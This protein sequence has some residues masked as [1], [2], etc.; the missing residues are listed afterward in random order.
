MLKKLIIVLIFLLPIPI[1]A[2]GEAAD[3][4]LLAVGDIML[5][6]YIGEAMELRGRQYPFEK[7]APVLKTGDVV[8]GNLESMLG[9][10][11]NSPFFQDK[12]YNLKAPVYAAK[13]LKES[14]FT[15]LNLA[16]NHA[17]DFGSSAIAETYR[18]LETEGIKAFGAGM[19]LEKAR[20]PVIISI[21][22]LRFAFLGYTAAH[23]RL[24]YADKNKA[25]A[26]PIRLDYI[27]NDIKSVRKKADI[28]IV[29]LHWGSEYQHYPTSE[30][31][32]I[33][34]RIIDYGADVILG[35]HPHVLQG[36]EL[37]K[38]RLI[39][40]SLGNFLFDQ[41]GDGTDRSIILSCR[42]RNNVLHSME[43]IPVDRFH[44]Y[45]PKKAEGKI[46]K[47]IMEDLKRFSLPLNTN[48]AKLKDI[49]L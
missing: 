5:D 14:G 30:Q 49:G 35:H 19:D 3:V 1:R 45:F 31:Q 29:L 11:D 44:S 40:Y 2:G 18:A 15:V 38:G 6:R 22:G 28:V 26:V 36:M 13:S 9:A 27:G 17:M 32:R 12:P 21:K 8:F 24:V 4:V 16:N 39:C 42:F 10:G 46:K 20:S 23:S 34:H 47:E 37:Y 43:I 25:G 48:P 33:A 41:K 7:I